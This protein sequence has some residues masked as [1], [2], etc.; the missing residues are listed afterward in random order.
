[1]PE[2]RRL[3]PQLN[4]R[5]ASV[6]VVP[7]VWSASVG[8]FNGDGKADI[9]WRHTDGTPSIWIMSGATVVSN[10]GF[11]T[12]PALAAF[13]PAATGDFNGDGMSDILWRDANGNTAMWMM[14]GTSIMSS[15]SVGNVPTTWTVQSVDAE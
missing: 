7:L 14:S 1:V 9:L 15:V 4:D 6:G 11:G 13:S 3:R 10:G 5:A 8:D 2:D 12:T